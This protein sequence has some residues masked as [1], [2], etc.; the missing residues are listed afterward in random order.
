MAAGQTEYSGVPVGEAYKL[1]V[2]I[3]I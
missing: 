1:A 2:I 3:N